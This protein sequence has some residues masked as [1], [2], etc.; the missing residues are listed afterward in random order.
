MIAARRSTKSC[1]T[2]YARCSE[3]QGSTRYASRRRSRHCEAG[4]A[5]TSATNTGSLPRCVATIS[6]SWGA[7]RAN[8][9][10]ADSLQLVLI[11]CGR[12]I[13]IAAD[14]APHSLTG[15]V[16]VAG[17][18]PGPARRSALPCRFW[19]RRIASS[20]L[21][22]TRPTRRREFGRGCR[23]VG[24]APCPGYCRGHRRERAFSAAGAACRCAKARR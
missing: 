15:T 11:E 2:T 24:V 14:K 6:S 3:D 18:M 16:M 22:S 13:L 10:P 21:P 12:P 20:S 8:G 19:P 1:Q 9:L 4:A 23:T 17:R 5:A 7:S